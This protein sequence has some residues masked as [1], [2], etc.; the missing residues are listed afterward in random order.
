VF[1]LALFN[2]AFGKTGE[3]HPKNKNFKQGEFSQT[4]GKS[5]FWVSLKWKTAILVT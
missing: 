1:L 2:P 5:P 3:N 4:A